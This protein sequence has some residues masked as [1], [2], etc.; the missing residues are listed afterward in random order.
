MEGWDGPSRP[1]YYTYVPWNRQRKDALRTALSSFLQRLSLSR[2]FMKYITFNIME[3]N[4]IAPII[5]LQGIYSAG[6]HSRAC[7]LCRSN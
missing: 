5:D 1:L 2:R 4:I 3:W 6:R 7:I